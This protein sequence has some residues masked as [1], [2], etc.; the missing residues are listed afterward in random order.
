MV[1]ALKFKGQIMLR[2]LTTLSWT[3]L[4]KEEHRN[5]FGLCGEMFGAEALASSLS[6]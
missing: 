6:L 4:A 5:I 3:K 1:L 2:F